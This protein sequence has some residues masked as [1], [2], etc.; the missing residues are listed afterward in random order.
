M[1]LTDADIR[2]Q[3]DDLGPA[4]GDVQL[5]PADYIMAASVY[6]PR[7][8]HIKGAGPNTCLV[9]EG[10]GAALIAKDNDAFAGWAR[11]SVTDLRV[12]LTNGSQIG[13]DAGN[14]YG[15][16]LRDAAIDDIGTGATGL[17]L[18]NNAYWAEGCDLERVNFRCKTG[19]VMGRQ[20]GTDSFGYQRWR[21]VSFNVPANGVGIDMGATYGQAIYVYNCDFDCAFWL[22]GSAAKAVRVRAGVNAV[23]NRLFMVG[24]TNTTG[25]FGVTK[26]NGATFSGYGVIDIQGA[27]SN[28]PATSTLVVK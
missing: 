6:Q 22:E 9:H 10:S 24:E 1:P 11:R 5:E 12:I 25:R 17:R 23:H 2:A 3:I 28:I 20:G 13:I 18:L 4:G 26:D 19:V 15:F 21:S 27:P 7:N 14:S 8:V 16:A